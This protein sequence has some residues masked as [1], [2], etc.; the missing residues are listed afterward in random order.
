MYLRTAGNKQKD[1]R[2]DERTE[3]RTCTYT[4]ERVVRAYM[5]HG[6]QGGGRRGKGGG[7][8]QHMVVQFCFREKYNSWLL[9]LLSGVRISFGWPNTK[10]NTCFFYSSL[11][12]RELTV[13]TPAF[14]RSD[15]LRP[16]KRKMTTH[17]S[18]ALVSGIRVAF[19]RS[20]AKHN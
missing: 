4:N 11:G 12:E 7:E 6:K 9:S 17:G 8:A 14:G 5:V 10:E 3:I 20:K 15:S 2:R 16:A 19:G 13:G 1:D 18:W